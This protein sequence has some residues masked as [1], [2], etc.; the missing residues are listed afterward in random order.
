MVMGLDLSFRYVYA[1]DQTQ[2][3]RFGSQ[4]L[5]LLSHPGAPEM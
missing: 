4:H 3:G 2:I 5:D 1:G